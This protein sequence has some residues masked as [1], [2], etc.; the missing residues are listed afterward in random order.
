MRQID[1]IITAYNKGKEDER[2]RIIELIKRDIL[3]QEKT[4]QNDF[5]ADK[6]ANWRIDGFKDLLNNIVRDVKVVNQGLGEVGG[7]N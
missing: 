3:H 7:K 1:E 6:I 5:T 4:K 2:E